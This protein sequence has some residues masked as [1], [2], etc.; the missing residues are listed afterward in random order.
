[1]QYNA[2]A[3]LTTP[4]GT[5]HF[6]AASKPTYFHD[7]TSCAG[8]EMAPVR[9]TVM[10]KPTSD[11]LIVHKAWHGARHVTLGGRFLFDTLDQRKT[12]E[13]A[14]VAALE[15]IVRADGTYAYTVVSG[16][17]THT[18]TLTVRCDVP[19][20]TSGYLQKSYLFG[21]VAAV[22]APVIT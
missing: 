18:R 8:L 21:L 14:L 9:A 6:N 2:A 7:P 19:L 16:A 10:D 22:P 11:G 15:S 4:G 13:D 1:M 20:S 17:G 12:L 3:T 5:V